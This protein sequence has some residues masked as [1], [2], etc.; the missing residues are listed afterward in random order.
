M[1]K[2]ILLLIGN[3]RSKLIGI[4]MLVFISALF[5]MTSILFLGRFIS[6]ILDLNALVNFNNLISNYSIN[7]VFES[8]EKLIYFLGYILIILYVVKTLFFLYYNKILLSFSEKVKTDLQLRLLDV[9]QSMP[10]LSLRKNTT[11]YYINNIHQLTQNF[12]NQIVL[13]LL[14]FF[15]DTIILLFIFTLIFIYSPP[16]IIYLAILTAIFILGYDKIYKKKLST[17]GEYSR[18]SSE[19]SMLWLRENLNGYKTIEIYSLKYF[20]NTKIKSFINEY[21]KNNLN[22]QVIIGIPKNL[23]ELI[24]IFFI[25]SIVFTSMYFKSESGVIFSTLSVLAVSAIR[26]IPAI[27]NLSSLLNQLRH[28]GKQ[29]TILIEDLECSYPIKN[30]ID[31]KSNLDDKTFFSNLEIR[32]FTFSYSNQ[33]VSLFNS[34][35]LKISRGDRI[36]IVGPSGVGKSTLLDL[37]LGLIPENSNLFV[38][39][40]NIQNCKDWW[41]SK[42]AYL[43]QVP[44]ILNGSIKENIAIGQVE[45]DHIQLKEAVKFARLEDL[46]N[47]LEYGL[48]SYVGELGGFLS[49]GQRQRIE[50]ARAYYFN[51]EV[52][53]LDESTSALDSSLEKDIISDIYSLNGEITIIFVTHNLDTLYGC[54]KIYEFNNGSL[55]Q[56]NA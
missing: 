37:I 34:L 15:S 29:M 48:E 39:N 17:Y 44:F 24:M 4:S 55:R 52:I 5:E 45:I 16:A 32:N 47:T 54:N 35:N 6:Y 19:N 33:S 21:S 56:V 8:K 2:K 31:K 42:V 20:F 14:R 40:I 41:Y 23:L 25:I 10:Y 1:I 38:N 28:Y 26:I 30:E 53:I 49:G 27:N 7:L 43:P 51:K 46:I 9:Y 18:K 22:A 11:A 3:N 36:G 50:L 12:S 13:P